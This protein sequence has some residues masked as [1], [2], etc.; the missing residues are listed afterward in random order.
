[1]PS[2]L[3]TPAVLTAVRAV[4]VADA[5]LAATLATAPA[6]LGGGPAIYAE[7]AV[8]QGATFPYLTLGAPTEIPWNTMGTKDL[9]KWGSQATFQ[10][11]ALSKETADDGN[12]TRIAR[13]KTL[14]D[15]ET[16]TVPGYASAWT[17]F[18]TAAAPF[19]EIVGGVV[20]RQFPVIFRALVH[21]S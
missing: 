5:T 13:V 18:E 7:D 11:K 1:M 8:P 4:L 12:Y 14:L 6:A 19:T 15:G 9:P 3:A 2:V 20:I 21:Q 16:L 10:V 17:E